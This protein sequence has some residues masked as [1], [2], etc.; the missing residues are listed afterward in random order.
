MSPV[1]GVDAA[2]LIPEFCITPGENLNFAIPTLHLY[3][4]YD[5]KPGFSGLACAPEKLS[6]ER[7]WNAL[8][9]DSHR[10]SINATEFAHQEYLDE[11]YR[12]ENE[13]THFCGFN[14]DLP[15][16]VYPV[17]RNFAAGSTVAFFRALF[18]ANCNDYLVY[19]EDPNLMSVD[20]TERHVNPT[21]ACPTPYC[22]WEPLL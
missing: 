19:L 13:V 15:K 3:G 12:L 14:E 4:G 8:S 10:W 11:F 5:P 20:T 21:G 17:F 1:D 2:G 22:T 7:F 9:P 18:D 16:D 6:N